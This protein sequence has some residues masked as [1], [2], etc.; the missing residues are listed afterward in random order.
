MNFDH[1]GKLLGKE[2]RVFPRATLRVAGRAPTLWDEKL[3]LAKVN[4]QERWI[5]LTNP[6]TSHVIKLWGDNVKGFTRPDILELRQQIVV[7]GSGVVLEPISAA[8]MDIATAAAQAAVDHLKGGRRKFS[9]DHAKLLLATVAYHNEHM[10]VP[11]LEQAEAMQQLGLTRERYLEVAEEL[12]NR[13]AL[14]EWVARTWVPQGVFVQLVGQVVP[15]VDVKQEMRQLLEAID[16]APQ[17]LASGDTF[18]ALGLPL[19]RAWHLLEYLKDH[20]FIEMRD[21]WKGEGR[22]PIWFARLA[23]KGKAFLRDEEELPDA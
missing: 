22:L 2:L 8:S 5:E 3:T 19:A 11:G 4:T 16:R 13:G 20:E 14:I 1:I 18:E 9:G 23:S 17:G 21:E 10:N 15:G 6:A 7:S 12:Y